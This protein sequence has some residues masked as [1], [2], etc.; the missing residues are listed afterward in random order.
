MKE[1]Q[2]ILEKYVGQYQDNQSKILR[3]DRIRA[4]KEEGCAIREKA[5]SYLKEEEEEL[6]YQH[7]VASLME[8]LTRLREGA[9]EQRGGDLEKSAAWNR[10]FCRLPMRNYPGRST[11]WKGSFASD[12]DRGRMRLRPCGR[13]GDPLQRD[14]GCDLCLRRPCFLAV[15]NFRFCL[16]TVKAVYVPESAP[17]KEQ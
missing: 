13:N 12:G 11:S 9:K 1:F 17:L 10:S 14:P 7:K 8:E 3:R 5:E 2:D 15:G 4:F 6:V 16:F